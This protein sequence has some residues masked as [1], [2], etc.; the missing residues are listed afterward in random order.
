MILLCS[1]LFG[2][3]NEIVKVILIWLIICFKLEI[4][5]EVEMVIWCLERLKLRLLSMIFNVGMRFFMLS[6]G[7]FM[8][9]IIMLVIG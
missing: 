3:C 2:V 8:F 6:K 4:I 1:L 7:L 9:I 5:L